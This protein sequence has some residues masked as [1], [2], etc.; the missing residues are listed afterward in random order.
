MINTLKLDFFPKNIIAGLKQQKDVMAWK[1]RK[2]VELTSEM[3]DLIKNSNQ[4]QQS[5]RGKALGLMNM[6][7]KKRKRAVLK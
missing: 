2:I 5:G 4:I 7:S 3:Y 1:K 6:G